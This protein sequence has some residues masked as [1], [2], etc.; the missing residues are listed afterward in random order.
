MVTDLRS[1]QSALIYPESDGK[2]MADN[3]RQYLWIVLIKEGLEWRFRNDPNVF[4]AADLLWYPVEGNNRL[5]AAPDVLVAVGR[6]KGYRGSY[7]QWREEGIAPQV[8]F[9]VRSPNNTQTEMD[10]KLVFYDHY[11]VEEYYLYDPDRNDLSG[12][13]RT[14]DRLTVINPLNGWVS[15]RLGIRFDL[16]GEELKIFHPDGEPFRSYL[17]VSQEW[18]QERQRAEEAR[19]RAEQAEARA[20]RLAERLRAAGIDPDGLNGDFSDQGD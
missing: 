8:V 2:P 12:W 17:E 16:S 18:E 11:A 6:P 9:E 3:T 19:Q 5:C 7:L 20:N 10:E 13:Q 14:G 4:V 15:P 1:S